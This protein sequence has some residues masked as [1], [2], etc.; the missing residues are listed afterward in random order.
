MTRRSIRLQKKKAGIMMKNIKIVGICG[1]LRKDSINK[2]LLLHISRNLPENYTFALADLSEI[3]L[4][5]SDLEEDLPQA[6]KGLAEQVKHADAVL[7]SSPEY[8]SSVTGVLKNT[9]DWLSRP[10]VDTPLSNKIVAIMGA[11]PGILGTV[12]AQLHLREILFA[13]NAQLI[14]RPEVLIPHASTKFNEFG[15]IVDERA[16]V[17]LKQLTEALVEEIKRSKQ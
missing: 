10:I 14:R 17:V 15:E 5:N 2:N 1:S 4:Y 12:R 9:L 7:I 3:P 13:L 11:T 16:V 6:V 8:N